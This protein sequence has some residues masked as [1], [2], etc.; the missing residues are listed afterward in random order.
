MTNGDVQCMSLNGKDCLWGGNCR[1]KLGTSGKIIPLTCGEDHLKKW[2][3]TGYDNKE[4]WCARSKEYF[5]AKLSVE[6]NPWKCILDYTSPIRMTNGDV[7]C[8]SL[9]GKDCLWGGN[10]RNQ[11]KT[12]PEKIIPLTCGEDHLKKW[13]ETGYDNKE[14]WCARS[15]EYFLTS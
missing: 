8:M 1:T 14:H 9:N 10:C 4:H 3:E 5:L 2:G 6:K 13:G 7:Q 15:K 12:S 11:L